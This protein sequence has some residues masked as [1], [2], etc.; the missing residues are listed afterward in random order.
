M[1]TFKESQAAFERALRKRELNNW[2]PVAL[3]QTNQDGYNQRFI[4]DWMFMSTDE[5]FDHFK[6]KNTKEYLHINKEV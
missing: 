3:N 5:N 6:N 2:S 1:N 4:G